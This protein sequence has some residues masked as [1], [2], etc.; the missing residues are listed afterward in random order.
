[1][2][3]HEPAA[4]IVADPA[5][6]PRDALPGERGAAH[7]YRT[8]SVEELCALPLPERA[9]RHVLLLWRLAS[10]VPEALRVLDAWGF[11]PASEIVW[12]KLRPCSTCCATGRVEVW[13][14]GDGGAPVLVPCLTSGP[15]ARMCPGCLGRGGTRHLGL[16]HY[17]RGGHEVAIIARPKRGRAPE[18]LD[19]SIESIFAAPM[20]IDVDGLLGGARGALVHSAKPDRFFEIVE[21]LYPGPRVEMFSRRTR[22]GWRSET[23]D[24]ADRLDE[25][26][27]VMRDVWPARER[28]ARLEAARR[29]A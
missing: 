22:P 13:R 17:V 8:M 15:T 4:V 14:F 25:V 6:Q 19:K 11:V 20:L 29:R 27:R 7:K 23:S 24:Q 2:T 10:M 18:R 28:A 5:W 12:R 9:E 21:Q 1:M 26:A 3:T 16:G